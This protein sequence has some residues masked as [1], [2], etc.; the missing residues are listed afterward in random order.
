MTTSINVAGVWKTPTPKIN[1]AGTWKAPSTI[2]INVAGTWKTVYT[3]GPTVSASANGDTNVRFSA[4]CYAGAYF[5]SAGTEFEYTNTGGTTATG[6][7]GDGVW[8]DSGSASGVWVIFTR[9]G[10]TKTDWTGT[11][12]KSVRYQLSTSRGFYITRTS[13]GIDTISGYFQFYD[14]STGGNLLQTTSTATW[15]AEYTV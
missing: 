1:V 2:K 3:S 11:Y 9:T 7:G 10:G 15:S 14:A 5:S 12:K 8:L 13:N 4:T 6:V